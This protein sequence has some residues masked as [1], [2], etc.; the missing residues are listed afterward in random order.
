MTLLKLLLACAL[1]IS[2]VAA[3]DGTNTR[4]PNAV[5]LPYV[6]SNCE[7]AAPSSALCR[8]FVPGNEA[9]MLYIHGISDSA[10][11]YHYT[12]TGT[13]ADGVVLKVDATV[14]RKDSGGSTTVV[15]NFGAPVSG[16]SIKIVELVEGLTL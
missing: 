16:T 13:R 5:L 4:N 14:L 10:V 8:T 2:A 15:V 11:A 7:G 1:G 6:W 9:Y 12:V 3:D